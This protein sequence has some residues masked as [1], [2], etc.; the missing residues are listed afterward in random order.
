MDGEKTV[1]RE[2]HKLL[3][4]L[5][6]LLEGPMVALGFVWLI[7]I[8]LELTRGL[9][10]TLEKISLLI[11]VIFIVHFLLTFIVAPH[12]KKFLKQNI[13]TIISLI[14][15]AIRILRVVRMVRLLRGVR[16]VKIAG[17]VNR[18]MRS[19][20][21]TMNRRGF[22]YMLILSV[23][24]VFAGAAGMYAFE[25]KHGHI[26]SYGEALWWTSIMIITVGSDY[27]PKTTEGRILCFAIALYGFAVL[28]Y[29]TAT[30]ATF[31]IGKDGHAKNKSDLAALKTEIRELKDLLNSKKT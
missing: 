6:K 8:I 14:V 4:Q 20:A 24:V 21:I 3:F 5:N 15:P 7:F 12:K 28:G 10:N 11:W 9:N 22:G 30:L 26:N 23:F 31:F 18:S 27:W 29:F 1:E 13:L 2:R 25:S 17:S 19:L 16:L